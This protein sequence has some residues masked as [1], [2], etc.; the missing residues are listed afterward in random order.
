MFW[1]GTG[2]K[3]YKKTKNPPKTTNSVIFKSLILIVVIDHHMSQILHTLKIY[4]S[5]N[6]QY[7]AA[8]DMGFGCNRLCKLYLIRI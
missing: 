7:I 8:H 1:L 6:Q 4:Q 3:D 5:N 2:S